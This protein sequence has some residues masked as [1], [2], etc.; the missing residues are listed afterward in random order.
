MNERAPVEVSKILKIDTKNSADFSHESLGSGEFVVSFYII[1]PI[2]FIDFA[3]GGA[4]RGGFEITRERK[5][6]E[7]VGALIKA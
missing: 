1:A 7:I 6:N 4:G 3:G 2:N 5:H